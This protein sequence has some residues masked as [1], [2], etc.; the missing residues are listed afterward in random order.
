M[1]SK[2]FS[3]AVICFSPLHRDARV[4][5]QIRA[6]TSICN[7]TAMGFTDPCIEGVRFIEIKPPRRSI[8]GKVLRG[9]LLRTGN[10]ESAYRLHRTVRSASKKI[11]GHDFALI[12]AN[13]IETLPLALMH[14]NQAKILYDAHEY[15]PKQFDNRFIWRFFFKR[16]IEY[17]CR[18]CIPQ[19]DAMT[20]VGPT[21][22]EEYAR[23]YGVQPAVVFNAPHYHEAAYTPRDGDIIRMVHHGGTF[24]SR[25]LE[26]MI[27]AMGQLDG[28][29]RLD[30]M[31][32]PNDPS[33][34]AEL[35]RRASADPRIAF[36][37]PVAPDEIVE[38]ISTYDVGLYTLTPYS[39]NA[40]YALP[41]K[42][43]DFLQ[44]RLC[45]A[46]G[47]SSE[48]KRLVERYACGVVANDFTAAALAE[49][50]RRLD[51]EQV[52]ACRRAADV[53]AYELCYERSAEVFLNVVRGILGNE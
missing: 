17:L 32:I 8:S 26:V 52:E 31:L 16:Y 50:L 38:R 18:A 25:R 33:Y 6:L 35:K 34:L 30:F 27:D 44:A 19:S 49:M 37:P 24:R 53:A 3:A 51:R 29:F 21:F 39:F 40:R 7:V 14:R 12:I 1:R 48:M 41:N 23:E 36:I 13:D 11:A 46:I 4:Q 47:P 43:F 42:F 2:P 5:R 9:Y 45:V 22:A 10:F 20:T 28:R 15:T